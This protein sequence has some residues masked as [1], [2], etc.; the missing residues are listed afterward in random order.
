MV[1]EIEAA[2]ERTAGNAAVQIARAVVLLG[3]AAFDE[4]GVFLHRDGDIVLAEAGNRHDDAVG[5]VGQLLDIVGRIGSRGVAVIVQRRFQ[6]ARNAVETDGG[7]EQGGQI[8]T[9]H[10]TSSFEAM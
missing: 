7:A 4:Q 2:L 3:D 8:E 10:C 9:G 5:V 1:G 6:Q